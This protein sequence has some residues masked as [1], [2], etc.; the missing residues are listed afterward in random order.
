MIRVQTDSLDKCVIETETLSLHEW[1]DLLVNAPQ[2]VSYI[3][4]CFPSEKMRSEY[5]SSI[6]GRPLREVKWL[7][8]KFLP[9]G[10]ILGHDHY[11]LQCLLHYQKHSPGAIST[12]LPLITT[13]MLINSAASKGATPPR[14]TIYWVLDLID[15]HPEDAINALRSYAQ[16]YIHLLPDGRITG[17]FDCIAVIRARYLNAL[18]PGDVFSSISS[19]D[20]EHLVERLYAAMGYDTVLT[21]RQKDGGRDVVATRVESGAKTR[22][23][24]DAKRYSKPVSVQHVRSILGV[25]S[26]EKANKGVVV[27][28]HGFTRDARKFEKETDR[29]ELIDR[30]SFVVLMTRF[31]GEHWASRLDHLIFDSQ[32]VQ[33]GK[34]S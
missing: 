6:A 11:F 25:V 19:R 9:P 1:L 20:F 34:H 24:I 8:S 26:Q 16:A 2:D 17:L 4:Y 32:R 10:S 30:A 14:E 31:Y 15:V 21:P 3:D 33:A 27:T 5:L 29:L 18:D 23:L 28:T 12:V 7:V 13:Q 22:I